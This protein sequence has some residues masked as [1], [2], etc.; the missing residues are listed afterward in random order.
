VEGDT[1][2]LFSNDLTYDRRFFIEVIVENLNKGV[3]YKY[4]IGGA[5]AERN[6]Q[7]FV[8][9]LSKKGAKKLPKK[10]PAPMTLVTWTT[11]IY[12]YGDP[13]KDIDAIS[14]LEYVYNSKACIQLS[15]EIARIMRQQFLRCWGAASTE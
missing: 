15:P 9:E 7:L 1:V 4:L 11:A 13:H 12:E 5:E 2:F 6:W 14:I 8:D 10:R 3:D